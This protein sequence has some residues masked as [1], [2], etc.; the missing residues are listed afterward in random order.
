M[1]RLQYLT[2]HPITFLCFD[3]SNSSA[4]N[5]PSKQRDFESKNASRVNV[6]LKKCV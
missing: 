6:Q 4:F 3:V 5:L 1:N 2:S